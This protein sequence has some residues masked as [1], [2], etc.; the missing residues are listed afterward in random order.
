M[1]ALLA[2]ALALLAAAPVRAAE[3]EAERQR[4]KAE[5]AAVAARF[6]EAHRACRARFAVTDC[7]HT[8]QRER[9]AA[10][11]DLRRQERVLNDAERKRRAAE[12]QKDVDERNSPEKRAQDEQRRRLAVSEQKEREARAAEKQQKKAEEDANKAAKGPREPKA[13]TG[14]H[15]PQGAPRTPPLPKSHGPTPEQAAANRAAYEA[16][17]RAAEEHNAQVRERAAKRRK[18]AASDLPMPR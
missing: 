3:D 1:K 18:P 6:D 11:A 5:R 9:N 8:A 13:A 17:L 4:I 2:L 7:V 15:G 12:R 16:R 10:L 14:P